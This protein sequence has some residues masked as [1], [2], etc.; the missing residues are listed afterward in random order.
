[1]KK[2]YC[3]LSVLLFSL[4]LAVAFFLNIVP[5]VKQ[6]VAGTPSE[7]IRVQIESYLAE[8][9]YGKKAFTEVYGMTH[10]L[11]ALDVLFT[12]L[13]SFEYVRDDAGI[14]QF[15]EPAFD[16]AP[17]LDSMKELKCVLNQKGIPLLF[18]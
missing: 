5:V 7:G 8:N 4:V 14:M 6:V 12:V 2:S 13:G 11:L 15:I 16:P 17:F 9:I 10:Q 1:M 18:E 3:V